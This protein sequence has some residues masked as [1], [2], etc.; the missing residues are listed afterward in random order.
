MMRR[1]GTGWVLEQG[2]SGPFDVTH[3]VAIT[4]LYRAG[5]YRLRTSLLRGDTQR[6]G[7]GSWLYVKVR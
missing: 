5:T 4:T 7:I 6:G 1:G 3:P 2:G